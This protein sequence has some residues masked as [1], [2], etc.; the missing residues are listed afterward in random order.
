MM[1]HQNRM[2]LVAG[3]LSALIGLAAGFVGGYLVPR[4]PSE[5]PAIIRAEQFQLVDQSGRVRGQLRLDEH[6]LAGLS[7]FGQ[8]AGAPLVSLDAS[9]KGDASLRLGDP[10]RQRAVELTTEPQGSQ[11]IALYHDGKLRL[12]LQ[13]QKHGDP[14]IRFYDQGKRLISLGLTSQG[15]PHLTFYGDNQKPALDLVSHKNGD[16]SLDMMATNGIPRIVLGL[17]NDQKSG[18][19]LFDRKGKTRVALMDEP[20]LFLLKNGKVMRMLP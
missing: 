16:R 6:G 12:G 7:L 2:W 19:G 18:L 13:L 4:P 9:P 3:I 15:D 10:N 20:S 5:T 17:K 8:D 14:A 11:H 1:E